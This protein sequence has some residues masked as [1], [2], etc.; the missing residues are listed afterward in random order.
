MK[1]T[2]KKKQPKIYYAL[3]IGDLD[4]NNEIIYTIDKCYIFDKLYNARKKYA[5]LT[6]FGD[7]EFINLISMER[8]ADGA[9]TEMETIDC[10]S[11]SD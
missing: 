11:N 6:L 2:I 10:W 1:F 4:E 8:D 9:E 5:N 7:H 3:E